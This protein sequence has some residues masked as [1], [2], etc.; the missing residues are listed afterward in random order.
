MEPQSTSAPTAAKRPKTAY[1]SEPFQNTIRGLVLVLTSNPVTALLLSL[2]VGLVLIGGYILLLITMGIAPLSALITVPLFMLLVVGAYGSYFALA[3]HSSRNVQITS[4]EAINLGIKKSILFIVMS[5]VMSIIIGIGFL[6][7]IVPGIILIAR[8]AL[9]PLVMFEENLGPIASIKRSMALTKGHTFEMLGSLCASIVISGGGSGLLF[10]ALAVAPYV[11]RYNDLIELEKSGGE[12]PKTH[13]LNYLAVVII[14]LL[15]AAYVGLIIA[16]AA[17][18][19]NSV[20]TK[21][22][23][24]N[25]SSSTS[26]GLYGN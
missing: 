6:L 19:S 10:G 15:V 13:W 24:L 20:D 7:L 16:L 22:V 21:A 2:V 17:A 5:I 18:T 3:A 25:T 1:Q 8:T 23:E 4:S 26:S 12:A 11:G 9:A 14:G